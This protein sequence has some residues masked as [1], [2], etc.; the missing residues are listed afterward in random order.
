MT[1]IIIVL[2]LLIA[3]VLL[4]AAKKLLPVDE[5]VFLIVQVLVLMVL[6]LWV[7]GQFGLLGGR[8]HVPPLW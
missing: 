7:L 6:F 3:G 2:V 1:L 8:P 5:K 4:W